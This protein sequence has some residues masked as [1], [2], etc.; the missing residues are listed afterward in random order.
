MF[1]NCFVLVVRVR[2]DDNIFKEIHVKIFNTGKMEIPG[3]QNDNILYK[4]LDIIIKILQP[5]IQNNKINNPEYLHRDDYEKYN[6]LE[7]NYDEE[8]T[9]NVLI[10]SNF[11][12]NF[13]IDRQSFLKF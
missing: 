12:C 8:K 2:D 1:Y 4:T 7:L 6:D 3:I 10:N 11:N 13:Y 9:E 5:I